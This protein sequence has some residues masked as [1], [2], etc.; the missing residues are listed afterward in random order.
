MGDV[1]DVGAPDLV[2]TADLHP[3]EK[4]G[5]NPMRGM[6]RAGS[7][8]LMDRLHAHQPHQTANPVTAHLGPLSPQL[9][10]HLAAAVKRTLQEQLV[11]AAHQ[12][13]TRRALPLGCVVERG[14]TDR[15]QAA[16]TAQAQLGGVARD[17]RLVFP[18]A[19]R[20]SPRATEQERQ[21]SGLA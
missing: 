16:L 15:K 4:I 10:D 7:R 11:D 6:L 13:Q 8:R 5:I 9:T 3:L 2:G 12:R 1:G 20:L 19:H 21:P 14:P 17:H 18:P